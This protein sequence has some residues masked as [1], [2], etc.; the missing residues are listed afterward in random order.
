KESYF[1]KELN[2]DVQLA[3]A[4][5]WLNLLSSDINRPGLP[6]SGYWSY[7]AYQRPQVIGKVENSY[8]C[9]LEPDVLVERLEKFFSYDIPCVIVCHGMECVGAMVAAA[10]DRGVPIYSTQEE[11]TV[12]VLRIINYLN[13]QLA[14]HTTQHGVLVDVFGTGL[15]IT[16]ESGVG[17]SET[18]LELVK[19]GHRLVADDVVEIRRVSNNRLVGEAPEVIKYFMEIRGIGI[20]DIATMYGIGAVIK[21]KSIDLIVHFELW[22]GNAEYD[23]LGIDEQYEEILG[24]KVSKVVIPIR[25]GRNLAVVLEVAARNLRLKQNGYNAAKTLDERLR[26]HAQSTISDVEEDTP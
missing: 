2:L 19:R 21:S 24:V 16:G 6:L 11:T 22:K 14:P 5:G 20:I 13:V 25:P 17:K 8:M 7:F 9:S 15:L 12:F 18:A 10:K 23:R 3:G 1:V 4:S 26:A